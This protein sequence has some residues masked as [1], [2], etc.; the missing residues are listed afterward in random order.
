MSRP[1]AGLN[2]KGAALIVVLATLLALV[3]SVYSLL[4][5]SFIHAREPALLADECRAGTLA[6]SGLNVALNLLRLDSDHLSDTPQE[7]WSGGRPG[8]AG[9]P[10]PVWDARGLT[11]N[12]IPCNAYLNLNAV[13][14]GK[15]PTS[16]KPNPLRERMETALDT[17]LLLKSKSHEL[18]LALQDWI[19][20]D[21]GQRLPGAEGM[22]YAVQGRG[23]VPRNGALTR[24]EEALLAEGWETLDPNWLRAAFTAWGE[25]EPRL[26]INFAPMGVLEALV[27]E[28]VPYRAAIVAFRDSSGF[29][30]VSQLLTATGMD[31]DTYAKVTPYLTVRSDQ[32]QVLVRAEVGTWV[33]TRRYVVDRSISTGTPKVLCADVLFTGTKS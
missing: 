8:M 4:D 27:P 16:E 12:I 7:P 24:P 26:N 21:N 31:E 1:R 28:L 17:L 5:T 29:Q 13:L 20:D 14:V 19:D 18:V 22:T 33:E 3:P 32:F 10:L 6:R 15:E 11:V 25:S 9:A 30:D 23:Y 2:Q